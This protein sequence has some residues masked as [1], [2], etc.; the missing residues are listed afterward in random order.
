MNSIFVFLFSGLLGG[1]LR[2]LF[3][4]AKSKI[5]RAS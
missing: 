2:G 4:I 1:I 3:G 5:D